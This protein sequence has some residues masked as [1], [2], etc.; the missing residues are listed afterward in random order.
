[1]INTIPINNEFLAL[2]F[3][4]LAFLDVKMKNIPSA[5]RISNSH[6]N[7]ISSPTPTI[8]AIKN[9]KTTELSIFF[10]LTHLLK[11]IFRQSYFSCLRYFVHAVFIIASICE[12]KQTALVGTSTTTLVGCFF[13]D[14]SNNSIFLRNASCF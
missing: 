2:F 3:V 4:A 5:N 14:F 1:M 10:K 7:N 11:S 12:M 8:I 13:G 9:T 6:W